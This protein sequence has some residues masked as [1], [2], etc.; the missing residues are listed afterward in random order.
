MLSYEW[1]IHLIVMLG[2]AALSL[3]SNSPAIGAIYG[4]LFLGCAGIYLWFI[5]HS[6][7]R[8]DHG[9]H[10]YMGPRDERVDDHRLNVA[11]FTGFFLVGVIGISVSTYRIGWLLGTSWFT[12]VLFGLVT[13]STALFLLIRYWFLSKKNA[14]NHR[15][16]GYAFMVSYVVTLSIIGI[17]MMSEQSPLYPYRISAW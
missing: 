12:Y 16:V 8:I 11:S 1:R 14:D 5:F 15:V 10:R 6:G 17:L 2:F 13:L 4:F 9:W 3:I 7:K